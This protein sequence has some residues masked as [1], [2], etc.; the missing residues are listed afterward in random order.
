[1]TKPVLICL[2]SLIFTFSNTFAGERKLSIETQD[3]NI[4]YSV[5]GI[6][7]LTIQSK[8]RLQYDNFDNEYPKGVY[9]EC[10]D[11][12]G[13]FICSVRANKAF[14]YHDTGIFELYNDV[15]FLSIDQKN[16]VKR[17]NTEALLWN[18]KK[19]IIY[20]DYFVRMEIDDDVISG[21]RIY[22]KQ[23]LSYYRLDNP[24]GDISITMS[25]KPK[26]VTKRK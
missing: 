15:E 3:I 19:K 2:F 21:Y 20:N 16:K 24:N 23:N 11:N 9:I 14:Q 4:S 12:K 8:L 10:Y 18:M 1:M 26:T 22:A 13:Q 7:I 25:Q 6:V 17:I 5:N